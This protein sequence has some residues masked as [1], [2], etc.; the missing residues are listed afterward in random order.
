MPRAVPRGWALSASPWPRQTDRL[1]MDKFRDADQFWGL[2]P[3]GLEN[4]GLA[5]LSL[6]G[7]APSAMA[8]GQPESSSCNLLARCFIAL[9]H[10][11][12]CPN[13]EE[14]KAEQVPKLVWKGIKQFS[15]NREPWEINE[16]R[17]WAVYSLC[18]KK[19]SPNPCGSEGLGTW[20]Q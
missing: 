2:Q 14:R 3:G 17:G 16:P 7:A 1:R 18:A 6:P 5:K 19:N 15:E 12:P 8:P 10:P 20:S 9:V 4:S 11:N 13:F